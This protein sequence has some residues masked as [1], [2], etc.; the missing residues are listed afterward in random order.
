MGDQTKYPERTRSYF[1]SPADSA[2]R[3]PLR[4]LGLD[5]TGKVVRRAAERI[6]PLLVQRLPGAH[7]FRPAT[8][9]V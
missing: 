7:E 6:E 5:V 3:P 8:G 9:R 4:D 2:T 1:F